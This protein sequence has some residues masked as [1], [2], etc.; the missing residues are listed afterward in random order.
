MKVPREA[1][2]L[3]VLMAAV[4][5]VKKAERAVGSRVSYSVIEMAVESAEKK[6]AS[7]DIEK[8]VPM[9]KSSAD[10]LVHG[11]EVSSVKQQVA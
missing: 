2:C 4:L 11:M 9:G 1:T 10:L 8:V 3:V 5:V 7:M 6:A